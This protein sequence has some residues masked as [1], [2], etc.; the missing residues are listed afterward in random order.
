ML[1]IWDDESYGMERNMN[2]S[3]SEVMRNSRPIKMDENMRN[4]KV[5]GDNSFSF[6]STF[7][8]VLGRIMINKAAFNILEYCDGDNSVQDICHLLNT[9]Y[10]IDEDIIYK[11]VD[12]TLQLFWRLKVIKMT[13]ENYLLDRFVYISDKLKIKYL[14]YEEL[15]DLVS[16]IDSLKDSLVIAEE[17]LGLLNNENILKLACK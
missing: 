17:G 1:K 4:I 14:Q 7:F 5:E 8:S 10:D 2:R 9:K 3:T 13:G 16:N 6:V 12:K 11:D 15:L